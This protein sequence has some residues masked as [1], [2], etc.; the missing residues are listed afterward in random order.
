MSSIDFKKIATRL[1]TTRLESYLQATS[2]DIEAAIGCTTGIPAWPAL[3][4]R[5][6][7]V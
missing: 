1:T 6:L 4:T 5:I 7:V 3:Y 2:G